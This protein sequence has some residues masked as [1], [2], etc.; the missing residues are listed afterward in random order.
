MNI[1]S[2]ND[3]HRGSIQ[4]HKNYNGSGPTAFGGRKEWP[5]LT[6]EV[7]FDV[8]EESRRQELADVL[9]KAVQNFFQP[10][11]KEGIPLKDLP[12]WKAGQAAKKQ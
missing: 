11:V 8:G 1:K 12:A 9:A 5:V 3:W 10:P 6:L 4:L 2:G 7:A